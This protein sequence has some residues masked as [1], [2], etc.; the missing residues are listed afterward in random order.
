MNEL[1]RARGVERVDGIALDLGV[2]SMQLDQPERGFSFRFDGPLDMRMGA[3]GPTAADLVNTLDEGAL[4]DVLF[5]LGEERFARRVAH[6]L[7]ER[8]TE[9][10]FTRTGD[11]ADAVRAV[12]RKSGDG[13]DPATR[14]FQALRV[15]VNDELGELARGL[16]GAEHLLAPAGRLVVVAFQSLEDRLV[17]TF[18]RG[19]CGERAGISRHMPEDPGASG[20][21]PSFQAVSRRA[22]LPTP[23]ETARNPR[24]R[25]ARLRVAERTAA[26][27]W[28]VTDTGAG[29]LAVPLPTL[30]ALLA[31]P[32]LARFGDDQ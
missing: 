25:S 17:K 30:G 11:L 21:G 2:S 3:H 27:S 5:H 1:L 15:A 19:R 14:T 8:R 28:P 29:A 20:P 23:E 32:T 24:A 9:A 18:L 6:A 31:S 4:A 22:S 10:P 16:I 26:P 13:I 7:V 12:V